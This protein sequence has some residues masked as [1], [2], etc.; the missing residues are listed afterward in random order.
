MLL[1]IVAEKGE[2][3]W[4]VIPPFEL[5]PIQIQIIYSFLPLES[6]VFV[7]F[8]GNSLIISA[9]PQSKRIVIITIFSLSPFFA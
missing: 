6:V 2:D 9:M 5:Y 3:S 7:R 4:H 1:N 8:G